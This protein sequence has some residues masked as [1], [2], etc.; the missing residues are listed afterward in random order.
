MFSSK[1]N[2]SSSGKNNHSSIQ[3]I[4]SLQPLV[5]MNLFNILKVKKTQRMMKKIAFLNVR[6]LCVLIVL[7]SFVIGCKS[8]QKIPQKPPVVSEVNVST[9]EEINQ[10]KDLYIQRCQRCH[11]LHAANEYNAADWANNLD[12]MQHKA[13]ITDEQKILIFKYLTHKD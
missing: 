7:F 10:G 13:K 11:R 1:G 9:I 6:F 2:Y 5:M 4:I 8:T 3:I 12:D